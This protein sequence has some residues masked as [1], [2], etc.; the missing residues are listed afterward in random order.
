[1]NGA[2]DTKKS[3]CCD[4]RMNHETKPRPGSDPAISWRPRPA[5]EM[6]CPVCGTAGLKAFV[7]SVD[8]SWY[9]SN[10]LDLFACPACQSKFFPDL[11]PPAYGEFPNV[12]AYLKF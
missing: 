2:F 10:A 7:L 9:N 1:M 4:A 5:R 6:V 8:T 11:K 12:D 3:A